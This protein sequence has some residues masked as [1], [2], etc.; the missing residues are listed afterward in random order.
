MSTE[1]LRVHYTIRHPLILHGMTL[2][3]ASDLHS[4]S[5]DD[6]LAD[7]KASDAILVPG[8]LVNRHRRSYQEAERF[9]RE[10]P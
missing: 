6:V 4:A 2:A 5:F 8:D 1:R 9:L 3:V 10:A 7:F